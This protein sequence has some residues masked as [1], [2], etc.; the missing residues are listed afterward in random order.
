MRD[1]RSG[2]RDITTSL[3]EDALMVVTIKESVFCLAFAP[4]TRLSSATDLVRLEAG[5]LKHDKQTA[6]AVRGSRSARNVCLNRK[7]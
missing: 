2:I 4:I 7:H 3:C 1:V 6:T 5:L